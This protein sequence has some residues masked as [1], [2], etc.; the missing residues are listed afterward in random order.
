MWELECSVWKAESRMWEVRCRRWSAEVY[1]IFP[2]P[3]GLAN[4]SEMGKM[5][6][7]FFFPSACVLNLGNGLVGVGV[8]VQSTGWCDEF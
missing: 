6:V 3:I 4:P 1:P 2:T 8:L 5:L 7:W